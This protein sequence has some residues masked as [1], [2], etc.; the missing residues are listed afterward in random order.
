MILK[1]LFRKIKFILFLIVLIIVVI[2]VIK[3][4]KLRPDV[5]KMIKQ[6]MN[7]SKFFSKGSDDEEKSDE[8][9]ESRIGSFLFP[10]KRKIHRKPRR[11]IRVADEEEPCE[12]DEET[13]EVKTPNRM[14]PRRSNSK[15]SKYKAEEL[16]RKVFEDYFDDYF[17]TC[18][19]NFLTNPLTGRPLELDGFNASLNLA[20][21]YQGIQHRKFPNP[22]HKT[23]REFEKQVERDNFKRKRLEELGIDLIEIPDTIPYNQ[24][25]KSIK[26]AL[27]E[28]KK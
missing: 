6:E 1:S 12:E 27:A 15:T 19:P 21:E 3:I 20:F 10:E 9:W 18:R 23:K 28:L 13:V 17:P 11:K 5:E 2:V 24:I 16:C 25:E 7:F 4:F 14:L 8:S 26:N 22:F